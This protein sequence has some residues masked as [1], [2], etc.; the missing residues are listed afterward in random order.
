MSS[1]GV[2][3][4]SAA[5]SGP[6]EVESPSTGPMTIGWSMNFGKVDAVAI[7]WTPAASGVYKI[8]AMSGTFYGTITT[9]LTTTAERTDLV[10]IGSIDAEEL[11]AINVA[12][13]E[14]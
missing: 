7:T 8:E 14:M 2:Y 5:E 9:P 6:L 1:V 4:G 10:P 11:D 3:A 13:V 12:I